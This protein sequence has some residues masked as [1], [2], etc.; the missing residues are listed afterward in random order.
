MASAAVPIVSSLIS[1]LIPGLA[2]LFGGKPKPTTTTTDSSSTQHGNTNFDSLNK[3]ILSDLQQGLANPFVNA[4]I[5]R[6]R[7]GA[8]DLS[9]FTA[10]G[11]RDINTSADARNKI[12]AN[13][14]ASR[15]LSYSPY[16]STQQAAGEDSRLAQQ[17]QF[18]QQIPLLRRQ[19]E[20]Q[21]IQGLIQGFGVLPTAS[22]QIG[23]QNSYQTGSS[24]GTQVGIPPNQSIPGALSGFGAGLGASGFFP[25]L[26]SLFGPKVSGGGTLPPGYT[27]SGGGYSYQP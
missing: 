27:N 10:G 12:T 17:N 11:L 7:E 23:S 1:S 20:D 4:L 26:S 16:A 22:Q 13:I 14:N 3:P 24:H 15:G 19:F 18:M 2:G 21:N 5:N 8:P 9:A 25:Q 6:Y